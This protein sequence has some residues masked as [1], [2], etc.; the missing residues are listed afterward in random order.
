MFSRSTFEEHSTTHAARRLTTA[1][2]ILL[3]T[4]IATAP[5]YLVGENFGLSHVWRVTLTN[6]GTALAAFVLRSS[7]GAATFGLWRMSRSGDCL[8]WSRPLLQRMGNR[9]TLTS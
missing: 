9:S 3:F 4:A 5:L 6:G 1:L 8:V 7:F 2:K